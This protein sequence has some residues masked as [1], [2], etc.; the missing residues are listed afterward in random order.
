MIPASVVP[1]KKPKRKSD[2]CMPPFLLLPLGVSFHQ[3]NRQLSQPEA[4]WNKG[5]YSRLRVLGWENNNGRKLADF[6]LIKY[7]K[8]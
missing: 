5:D 4:E 3:T 2:L 8:I 1:R 7:K 6:K